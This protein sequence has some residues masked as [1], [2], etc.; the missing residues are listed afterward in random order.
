MIWL[1][2]DSTVVKT[3]FDLK[4][5]KEEIILFHFHKRN[6]ILIACFW[7]WISI[8]IIIKKTHKICMTKVETIMMMFRFF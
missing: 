7:M 1:M 8:I 5:K 6:I 4:K 3:S 2:Y